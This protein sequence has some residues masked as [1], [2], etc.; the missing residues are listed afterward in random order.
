VTAERSSSTT[1]QQS[2][3]WRTTRQ[4]AKMSRC[5]MRHPCTPPLPFLLS[6]LGLITYQSSFAIWHA[7]RQ[8]SVLYVASV[9]ACF[10]TCQQ[11][12]CRMPVEAAGKL[13]SRSSHLLL[14][15]TPLL[16][17]L[18]QCIVNYNRLASVQLVGRCSITTAAA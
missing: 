7:F 17:L 3:L 5:D 12:C 14:L 9:H 18:P 13:L 8:R 4:H 2:S 1:K 10:G 15:L 11:R 6:R 16:L